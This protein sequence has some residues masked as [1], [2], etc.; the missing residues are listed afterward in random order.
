MD[1]GGAVIFI[2]LVILTLTIWLTI[3]CGVLFRQ[4]LDIRH[5]KRMLEKD[6]KEVDNR[7]RL[8]SHL[9]A[10]YAYINAH[11]IRGPLARIL[12]LVHLLEIDQTANKEHLY[13]L[14]YEAARELDA[15][16]REMNKN[17][18]KVTEKI[19]LQQRLL[20]HNDC[21]RGQGWSKNFRKKNVQLLLGLHLP[22]TRGNR[23]SD[24]HTL[25]P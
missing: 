25:K 19:H 6:I 2:S 23:A 24:H 12:G 18:K 17:L 7:R 16:I 8:Q 22:A 9:T 10:R 20:I 3:L 14:I 1:S 11:K 21:L 5:L 13:K 15:S 4:R